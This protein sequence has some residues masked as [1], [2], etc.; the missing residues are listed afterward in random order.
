[1]PEGR[2]GKRKLIA[3]ICATIIVIIVAVA[4][5]GKL[6][7]HQHQVIAP[8][9]TCAECHSDRSE[10]DSSNAQAEEVATTLTVD[11]SA[12]AVVVCRPR[13]TGDSGVPY[14][15]E[16]Y[17]QVSASNGKAQL[18]LDEGT[19]VLVT[20]QDGSDTEVASSVLVHASTG[21]TGASEISL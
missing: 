8:G 15:P 18:M 5:Y 14:V 19:W 13:W 10:A 17:A 4:A 6:T 7:P 9:K 11:T 1:M 2:D 21:G 16:R 3:A 20:L 12:G